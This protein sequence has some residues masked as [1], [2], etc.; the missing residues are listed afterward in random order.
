VDER[1]FRLVWLGPIGRGFV[2]FSARGVP[3]RSTGTTVPGTTSPKVAKAPLPT[4][5]DPAPGRRSSTP[6]PGERVAALEA[7][8]AALERWR[9]GTAG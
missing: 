4:P 3:K 2:R 6:V 9:E 5:A 7:R 8:V 1:M